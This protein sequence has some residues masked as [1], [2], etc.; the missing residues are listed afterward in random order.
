MKKNYLSFLIDS[1][2]CAVDISNILE[3]VNFENLTSIPCCEPYIEGMIY[4]REQGITVI[5]LRKKFGLPEKEPDKKTKIIVMEVQKQT[6]EGERF[7]LYGLVADQVMDV[8]FADDEETLPSIKST[9]P[10]QNIKSII[11]FEEKAL[12]ELNFG[13]L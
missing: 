5:N 8:I 9:I 3:V 7:T 13:D 12:I 4:S 2:I 10:K 6:D 11:K 1:N